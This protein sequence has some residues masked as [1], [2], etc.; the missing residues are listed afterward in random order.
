MAACPEYNLTEEEVRIIESASA[1]HDIGKIAIP[2]NV[3]LKPGR[4]TDEEFECMK[5]HSVKGCE[6]HC[7]Y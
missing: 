5:S 3:L 2:D 4:L 1:L 7:K 6:I